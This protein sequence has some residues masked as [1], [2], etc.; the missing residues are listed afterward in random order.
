MRRTKIVCTLGPASDKIETLKKMVSSGMNVARLNFSHGTHAYHKKMISN[1]RNVSK[2]LKTPI[3]ILQDLQG[4]KIRVGEMPKKGIEFKPGDKVIVTTEKIK[5]GTKKLISID[6]ELLHED[7]KKGDHILIEDGLFDFEV[8]KIEGQSIHCEVING[9]VLLS[10]KGVNLPGVTLSVSALTEKDKKDLFFG[11]KNNVD[12]VALSFVSTAKD[13][14]DLR[15]LIKDY[16]KQLKIKYP[17]PIRII[18]KIERREA[19]KNFDE[20]LDATDGVMVARGDLGVEL[21]AEDVPLRQKEIIDK[22]LDAAKP[23]IVATQ[24][25]DSMIRNPRPTRAEVS[26]VANAVID[27]TDAVMLSGETATGKYPVKS[28]ETMAK[29]IEKTEQ[30]AYDDLVLKEK[31]KEIEATDKAIARVAKTLVEH[32]DAQAV[33]VAS[34]SGYTGRVVSRY[35]PELPILISCDD[36]RVQRQL[37]LSWGVVPFVI[38]TC[39]SIEELIERSMAYLKK[40]KLI[41]KEDKIIV[42]AGEPVGRSGNVNFV[43]IKEVD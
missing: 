42:V 39:R 2:S 36:D 16:E 31:V 19:I 15:Y 17:K 29:I 20:I 21:P 35:R 6:Y 7:I 18:V 4:P 27:H 37:V 1:V 38:P 28:V 8:K 24:M 26:D 30:S 13:V 23:V 22:C 43:E 34:L 41:K 33:L 10:H 9:G 32:V 40:Q 14:I 3:G 12:F 5:Q 25:L 11:V